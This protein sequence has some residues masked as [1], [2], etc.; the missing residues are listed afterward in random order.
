MRMKDKG[1]SYFTKIEP[2][3][4]RPALSMERLVC[5]VVLFSLLCILPHQAAAA[6]Q[7]TPPTRPQTPMS[8]WI[9]WEVRVVAMTPL[10]YPDEP[11]SPKDRKRL[12]QIV[13]FEEYE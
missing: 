5:S 6:S 9:S 1:I 10:G 13:C 12:D 7:T 8:S 11:A 3:N 2:L 4:V